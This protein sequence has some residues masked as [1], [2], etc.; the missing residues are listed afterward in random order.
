[1]SIATGTSPII[2]GYLIDAGVPLSVQA[3][4]C[5][6]YIMAASWIARRVEGHAIMAH[7]RL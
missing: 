1:M 4:C 6:G 5:L 7:A 2:M 3:A